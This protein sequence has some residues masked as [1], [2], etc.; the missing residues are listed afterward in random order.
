M[1]KLWDTFC[2]WLSIPNDLKGVKYP[3]PF[4][5]IFAHK[6]H[7]G[8]LAANYKPIH[9]QS[10]EQYIRSVGQIF[11]AMGGAD[12]RLN[13]MGAIDSRLGQK[14]AT[15]MKEDPP[16]GRVCPLP[17]SIFQCMDSIVQGSSPRGRA[18][19]DLAWIAF[20]FPLRLGKYYAGGIDTVSTPFTL[21]DIH[22]F[23]GTQP[24]QATKSSPSACAAATFV[25][26]LFTMQKHGVKG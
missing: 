25:G 22:F 6:V 7:T 14:F 20:F 5:Q 11:A 18:I 23:V 21:R 1:W 17:V 3:I 2:A 26:L 9:K 12:P 15:Y 24:T 4:L 10:V 8:V 19:T 16:P 13:T